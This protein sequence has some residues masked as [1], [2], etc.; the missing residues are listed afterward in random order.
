MRAQVI[1][2]GDLNV[3]A[4][5]LDVHG[6][7]DYASMYSP[8]EK[9][10]MQ[11]L[12]AELIDSWRLQHPDTRDTFTVWDERTNARAFNKVR[13]VQLLSVLWHVDLGP[14]ALQ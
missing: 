10:V 13:P 12:L 8:A 4:S 5:E 3:A 14:A 9:S 7:C 6:G 11:A 1:L 2:M